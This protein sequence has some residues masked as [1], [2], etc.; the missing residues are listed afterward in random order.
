[1]A[2]DLGA[3]PPKGEHRR[4]P[5]WGGDVGVAYWGRSG[6]WLRGPRAGLQGPRTSLGVHSRDRL[7]EPRR[8]APELSQPASPPPAR[9][10]VSSGRDCS[11]SATPRALP[12]RP[13]PATPRPVSRPCLCVTPTQVLSREPRAPR[14]FPPAS[15]SRRPRP[16]PLRLRGAAHPEQNSWSLPEPSPPPH[17]RDAG[18][19][20]RRPAS[21]PGL[22]VVFLVDGEVSSYL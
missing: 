7:P 16:R 5:E 17:T 8:P 6:H 11:P 18:V 10:K 3:K 4:G 1:M 22:G 12:E 21:P 15:R 9:L 19:P 14:C 2:A 20:S 13:I